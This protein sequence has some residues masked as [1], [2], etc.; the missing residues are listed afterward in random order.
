MKL[1]FVRADNGY[2]GLNNYKVP[3]YNL[4]QR[5]I[6]VKRDGSYIIGSKDAIKFGYGSMLNLRV[7][8]VN[9]FAYTALVSNV[10]AS[11]NIG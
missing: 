10:I 8:L 7:N 2:L 4:L 11:K 6:E 5:Y 1:G 3:R 9:A